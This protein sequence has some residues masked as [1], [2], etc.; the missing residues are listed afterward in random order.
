MSSR[1]RDK[2][3]KNLYQEILKLT[4][5]NSSSTD[6]ASKSKPVEAGIEVSAERARVAREHADL[7]LQFRAQDLKSK[8]NWAIYIGIVFGLTVLFCYGF[9]VA[10]GLD[11]LNFEKYPAAV[12]ILF[13]GFTAQIIGLAYIVV[14]YRFSNQS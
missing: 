6:V 7:D 11:F 5:S 10:V 9:V 1:N 13:G 4:S 8:R 12:N 14:R 2:D 3:L